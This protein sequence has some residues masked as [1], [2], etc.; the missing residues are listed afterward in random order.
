MKGEGYLKPAMGVR[1]CAQ[2]LPANGLCK[3]F[4]LRVRGVKKFT[5]RW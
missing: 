3:P 2:K 5:Y 4:L 1:R